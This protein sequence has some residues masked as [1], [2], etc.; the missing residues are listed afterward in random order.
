[1]WNFPLI[2]TLLL[3]GSVISRASATAAS[4]VSST[5]SNAVLYQFDTDGNAIDLTSAKID[6]LG[7]AYIWYGL[8]KACGED[9]CG[10]SSYSSSDLKSW[11]FN[12]LLFDPNTAAIKT[13]CLAPNSGNC[14]RPHIVYSA[15]NHDYVLWVNAGAPG[16]VIFTSSSPTSGYVVNDNR[17]LVGYQPAGPFQG[18]DF[19]VQVMN[20][21]GY[22]V[23]SLIDFN[24]LGASIWPPFLQSMYAQQLSP[25]MR[26]TTG[27]AYHVVSAAGDL[28][29]YEAESPDIFQRGDYFYIT[30]SNTCGYCD[31]TLLI[32]YRSKSLAGPWVRQIIS[33]DT[34]G[35]QS[36][37][38]LTLPSPLGPTSYLHVADI[39]RTAPLAGTRTASHGHQVQKLE[40][41]NDGTLQDL[42]CSPSKSFT[43]AF[44]PGTNVS[45]TGQAVSATDGSGES[46]IYSATCNLPSYQLYQ[47]WA[48]SKT[49]KLSEV[50]VNIAGIEPTGNLSITIFRYSNNT[51]FFTPRYIWET[52]ATY[53]LVPGETSQAFEAIHV[54]VNA[55]VSK[56]DRLGIALVGASV[57]QF[58]TLITTSGNEYDVHTS[59]RTLFAIGANQVSY[60]GPDGKTPPVQ[61]MVGKQIK[62]YAVVN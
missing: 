8:P 46:G 62:W 53:N 38:V 10:I 48:S 30:A 12:G 50:S 45:S 32:L 42:D 49:G 34:C 11:K 54:P 1:M 37:G 26:N 36:N 59:T 5:F 35:G 56:G 28:V 47:T 29:D 13:L 27:S 33:A 4:S 55:S 52:L 25:D 19:T 24:T 43:V 61:V 60:R 57:T 58:C 51:N 14:G 21:T 15:V 17:A 22:L 16:Y 44:T 18:G 2:Q 7:G 23:Y 9:F 6:Y 39:I 41:N 3:A 40:F 20:G 31:G